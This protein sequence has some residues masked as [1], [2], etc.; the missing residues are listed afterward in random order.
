MKNM[1]IVDIIENF[2]NWVEKIFAVLVV[3]LSLLAALVVEFNNSEV[4]SFIPGIDY[5]KREPVAIVLFVLSALFMTVQFFIVP[6]LLKLHHHIESLNPKFE[7]LLMLSK[8]NSVVIEPSKHPEIWDGFV[9]SYYVI[10]APWQLER[11]MENTKY[12]DMIDLHVKR[13]QNENLK[14]TTY[15]VFKR[16]PFSSSIENFAKF[17]EDVLNKFPGANE[18]IEVIEVENDEVPHYSLFFGEKEFKPEYIKFKNDKRD[19]EDSKTVSYSI[20]YINDKPFLNKDGFPNWAFISVN[21][22]LN[23]ILKHY[24]RSIVHGNH[25]KENIRDFINRTLRKV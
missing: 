21:S 9:N 6:K 24:I 2:K 25:R 5:I 3:V 22:T 4:L 17:M 14:K 23:E 1:L 18:K 19:L 11:Y 7:E 16:T 12:E 8:G 10:N 20:L 15:I 13:Y